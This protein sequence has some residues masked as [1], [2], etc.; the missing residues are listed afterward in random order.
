MRARLKEIGQKITV[1]SLR[2]CGNADAFA[3]HT[4]RETGVRDLEPLGNDI[5]EVPKTKRARTNKYSW[6]KSLA[7]A[8]VARISHME[9]KIK[10]RKMKC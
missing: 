3:R 1:K 4:N 9:I 10:Y 6:C 2:E 5:G 8:S 7:S